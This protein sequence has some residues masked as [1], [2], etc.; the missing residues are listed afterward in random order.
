M[1]FLDYEEETEIN[2]SD[3][4]HQSV[5]KLLD[6]RELLQELRA[7][8]SIAEF[9]K[10]NASLVLKAALTK[11]GEVDDDDDTVDQKQRYTPAD[12]RAYVASEV[13]CGPDVACVAILKACAGDDACWALLEDPSPVST[14]RDARWARIWLRLFEVARYDTIKHAPPLSRFAAAVSNNSTS[15]ADVAGTLL[16][17]ACRKDRAVK[18]AWNDL[19]SICAALDVGASAQLLLNALPGCASKIVDDQRCLA[20]VARARSTKALA[21]VRC[22]EIKLR[23]PHAI[24]ATSSS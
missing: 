21:V 14:M 2:E 20:S 7:T 13:L 24:D 9:L 17:D 10:T 15:A 4:P 16:A 11:D 5:T 22:V 12:R 19:R 6:N 3:S 23:A 18:V 1:D 8:P